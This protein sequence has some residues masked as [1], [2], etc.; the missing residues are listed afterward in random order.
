MEK[1]WFVVIK[2]HKQSQD[3]TVF[4]RPQ[5]TWWTSSTMSSFTWAWRS[6][7]LKHSDTEVEQDRKKRKEKIDKSLSD[8]EGCG[9]INEED[10]HCLVTQGSYELH[11]TQSP[12]TQ[13]FQ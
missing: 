12:D 9:K 1:R 2:E 11:K 6:E 5:S 8:V 4:K 7:E 10:T 3:E 13:S